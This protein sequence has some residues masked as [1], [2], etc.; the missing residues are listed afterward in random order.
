MTSISDTNR[1]EL[2]SEAAH[3]LP[4]NADEFGRL[5][6][7]HRN[8]VVVVCYRFLGSVQDAEDAA[9]ETALRSWRARESYRGDAGVRTW[10]HRIATR[11]CL[12]AIER[13]GRRIMPQQLRDPADPARRPDPPTE[14]ILWL[15]PLPDAYVADT[16]LD[17]A[18]RY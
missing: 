13:R 9:Q 14:E 17:P 15:E 2:D 3:A 11:V 1:Q 5:F 4:T 12:D 10:L 7:D 8:D 6:E 18:G 16:S